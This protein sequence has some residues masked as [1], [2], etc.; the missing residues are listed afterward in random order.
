MNRIQRKEGRTEAD[1]DSLREVR[2]RGGKA[3]HLRLRS[4]EEGI[5]RRIVWGVWLQMC[6]KSTRDSG[7]WGADGG[8]YDMSTEDVLHVLGSLA[9]WRLRE[10]A[11]GDGRDQVG[12]GGVDSRHPRLFP[13]YTKVSF[14]LFPG[15]KQEIETRTRQ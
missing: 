2:L 15:L 10:R 14:R 9:R 5:L 7:A 8:V 11:R 12:P 13:L 3:G 1:S 4:R 6:R